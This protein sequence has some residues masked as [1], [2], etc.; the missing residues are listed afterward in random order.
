VVKSPN[1]YA[2]RHLYRSANATRAAG[3][4]ATAT[5]AGDDDDD[6]DDDASGSDGI[7]GDDDSDNGIAM[8]ADSSTTVRHTEAKK[9][10]RRIGEQANRV[11]HHDG[12]E[13]ERPGKKSGQTT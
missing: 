1:P 9:K 5:T 6:D 7:D 10:N 2:K 13:R 11:T 3:P 8:G 12:R 4:P